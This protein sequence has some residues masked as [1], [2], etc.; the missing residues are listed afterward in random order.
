[1]PTDSNN[2]TE[3]RKASNDLSA[4]MLPNA[5]SAVETT[6]STDIPASA[7]VEP[8]RQEPL[9]SDTNKKRK[10]RDAWD[11]GLRF[12]ASQRN[13]EISGKQQAE[14]E[15]QKK[16]E[17][18]LLNMPQRVKKLKTTQPLQTTSISLEKMIKQRVRKAKAPRQ[19][20]ASNIQSKGGV[21]VPDRLGLPKGTESQHRERSRER[22]VMDEESLEPVAEVEANVT[23]HAP[24]ESDTVEDDED[25]RLAAEI[26]AF[27]ENDARRL[28][29]GVNDS[30][31]DAYGEG[32][33]KDLNAHKAAA[34]DKIERPESPADEI[35]DDSLDSLFNGPIEDDESALGVRDMLSEF[36]K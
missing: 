26:V 6:P 8:P 36:N 28:S 3:I 21:Q 4:G 17:E 5:N 23:T 33:E 24:K 14:A 30:R 19:S 10:T 1:M 34:N 25:E 32:F 35:P 11:A 16:A 27:L 29:G 7:P 9:K 15:E 12:E 22:A 31:D 20:K 18:A 2:H 13:W